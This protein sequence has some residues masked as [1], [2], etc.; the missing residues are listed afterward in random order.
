MHERPPVVA[1][2]NGLCIKRVQDTRMPGSGHTATFGIRHPASVGASLLANVLFRLQASSYKQASCY[3][4]QA[5]LGCI[6]QHGFSAVTCWASFVP[7]YRALEALPS[8]MYARGLGPF[9]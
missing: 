5:E 6:A 4:E 7:T 1:K 9:A 8:Y 2:I 3:H